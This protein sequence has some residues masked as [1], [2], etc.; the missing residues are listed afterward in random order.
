VPFGSKE[1]QQ[2]PFDFSTC[3][4]ESRTLILID[5]SAVPNPH[6]IVY[7]DSTSQELVLVGYQAPPLNTYDVKV[8]AVIKAKTQFLVAE[9]MFDL[10]VVN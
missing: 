5:D 7:Y 1:L 10:E 9:F 4:A 3:G 8:T 2:V 6:S